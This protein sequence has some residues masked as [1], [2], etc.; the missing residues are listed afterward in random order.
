MQT[1]L[2]FLATSTFAIIFH[3]AKA[4]QYDQ[5]V[6]LKDHS[7]SIYCSAGFEQRA[8]SITKR[9]DSAIAYHSQLMDFRPVITLLVLSEK[10]WSKYTSFPVY[11]MPH[12]NNDKTLVVA[13]EDN[14]FWKSFLPPVEQLPDELGK[15]VQT[16]YRRAD[17]NLSMEVFF[18]LLALHELGHAFHFQGGLKMQR[19]W[20][21]EVFANILLHTYVAEKE[22]EVLPALTLF[23]QMVIRGG[24]KEFIYTSLKDIEERYDEIGKQY[25]KNYGWYQ[26]RWHAAAANIYN[27][28]GKK[29][30]RKLW[31]ALKSKSDTL[32]DGQL[33]SFL[34]SS[35]DK[36]LADMMRNWDKETIR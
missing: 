34:E 13:A 11:G 35:V 4:Q 26:C 19:K 30:C 3:P 20:M 18:D 25:P 17:G 32:T 29:I 23:P 2:C 5:L 12:Y 8:S 9:V 24:T 22:P 31:D 21:G 28:T 10:D 15:Q 16:V 33:A 7:V 6:E 1:F 14:A 36:S 27:V